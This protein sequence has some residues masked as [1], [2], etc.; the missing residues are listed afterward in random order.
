MMDEPLLVVDLRRPS[1]AVESPVPSF[2]ATTFEKSQPIA[3]ILPRLR[4]LFPLPVHL[5]TSMSSSSPSSSSSNPSTA[6]THHDLPDSIPCFSCLTC[7]TKIVRPPLTPSQVYRAFDGESSPP[8]SPSVS[9]RFRFRFRFHADANRRTS[10]QSLQWK[11]RSSFVRT[12]QYTHS[13]SLLLSS[14][15]LVKNERA[16]A[17]NASR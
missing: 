12:L 17:R 6:P 2:Y 16:H 3:S 13:H 7:S 4:N 14:R 9:F 1:D 11:G 15:Q 10:Q 5:P 8:S